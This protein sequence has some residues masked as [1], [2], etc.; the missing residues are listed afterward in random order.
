MM[1]GIYAFFQFSFNTNLLILTVGKCDNKKKRIA[2][3]RITD[4][5][6]EFHYFKEVP[7]NQLRKEEKRLI[8]FLKNNGLK[9]Y[10]NAQEQFV[11]EDKIKTEELL[12]DYMSLS[13]NKPFKDIDYN[14]STL[15]GD[16][17]DIRNHRPTSAF[18]PGEPAMTTTKAGLGE[19]YR[20]VKTRF[21]PNGKGITQLTKPELKF[22]DEKSWDVWQAARMDALYEYKQKK[23]PF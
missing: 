14:V 8:K 7:K 17:E 19:K 9:L 10:K 5:G 20:K 21:I 6:I 2:G 16:V 12:S 23:G 13:I 11:I 4:A 18:I 15:D 22:I 1:S 3:Y